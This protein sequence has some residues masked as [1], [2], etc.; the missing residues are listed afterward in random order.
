MAYSGD[1]ILYSAKAGADLSS[2]RYSVLELNSEDVVDLTD[3]TADIPLGIL[4]T[5]PQSGEEAAV[6][7]QGISKARY[8][9]NVTAG[10]LLVC[11]ASGTLTAAGSTAGT[12]ICAMALVT[13]NSGAT[14]T[15]N[16]FGISYIP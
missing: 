8:G 12:K 3:G 9:G 14:G 16:F 7:V 1:Q 4:Q 6:C 2:L 11:T 10:N 5:K 13:A 15:V